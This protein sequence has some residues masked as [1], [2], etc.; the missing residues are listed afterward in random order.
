MNEDQQARPRRRILFVAADACDDPDACDPVKAHADA[1]TNVVVVAPARTGAGWIADEDE[2][3]AAAVERLE[4]SVRCLR[5]GGLHARGEVGDPEPVQAIADALYA[6]PA[7]EVVVWHETEGEVGP[8]HRGVVA[9]AR[10]RF[11]VPIVD[12]AVHRA[13]QPG[14]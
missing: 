1:R 12:L 4:A 10:K 8:H 14:A 3:R 7:E 5:V 6:F 13:E 2:D 9:R 11:G